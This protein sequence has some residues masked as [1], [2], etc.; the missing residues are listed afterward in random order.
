MNEPNRTEAAERLVCAEC[1][2]VPD[3]DENAA[4]E[5]RAY[6]DGVGELVV[7]SPDCADRGFG[8]TE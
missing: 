8:R 6:S 7:F 1:G 5:W 4:D 3:A 2:R